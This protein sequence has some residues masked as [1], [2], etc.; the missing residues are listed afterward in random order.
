MEPQKYEN[1]ILVGDVFDLLK[2]LPP[3]VAQLTITSPPYFQQHQ[4][5]GIEAGLADREIGQESSVGSYIHHLLSVFCECLRVTKDEGSIVFNL[6]D[7]YLSNGLQMVPARFAIRVLDTFKGV[8]LINEVRWVKSNP[9]PHTFRKRLITSHE[10]FFHFVKAK[11]YYFCLDDLEPEV[12]VS[13][14]PKKKTGKK[15]GEKYRKHIDA[16]DLTTEEKAK[17]LAALNQVVAEVESGK[18]PGYRM[19]IR[20][21]HKEA[22]GGQEGGRNTQIR[23]NG[24]SIIRCYDVPMQKDVVE[25]R[26]ENIKGVDHPCPFPQQIIERFVKICTK[27]GDLVLDPFIGSGTTATA[28]KTLGRMYTGIEL[29]ARY[30][31][32]TQQRLA[33]S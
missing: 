4:Y 12:E 29:S 27:P 33:K 7:K 6:G 15:M 11:D 32:D 8:F 18:L 17:A 28:A 9:T 16:S 3:K 22:Y 1:Q 20:G 30:A 31:Q 23:E 24:F 13:K 19:K 26:V 21:I 14:P 5:E 2:Q 25:C 10:P